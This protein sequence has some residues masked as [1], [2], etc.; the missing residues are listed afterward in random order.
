[1]GKIKGINTKNSG[2]RIRFS[3]NEGCTQSNEEGI[4]YLTPRSA[5]FG[6][7]NNSF[8]DDSWKDELKQS[9]KWIF[10]AKLIYDGSIQYLGDI[11]VFDISASNIS[12]NK[13]NAIGIG[14]ILPLA[15]SSRASFY[16]LIESGGPYDSLPFNYVSIGSVNYYR[17]IQKTGVRIKIL[18][19][20]NDIPYTYGKKKN[21]NIDKR[22]SQMSS[23]IDRLKRL[24]RGE[25]EL[26]S[27]IFKYEYPVGDSGE[28]SP[29]ICFNVNND[30]TW[31]STNMQAIIGSNG[32]GKT[33][34]LRNLAASLL[35]PDKQSYGKI[36]FAGEDNGQT[37]YSKEFKHIFYISFSIL[38]PIWEMKESGDLDGK[39]ITI[40]GDFSIFSSGKLSEISKSFVSTMKGIVE[41]EAKRTYW[42]EIMDSL[43]FIPQFQ[44]L[45]N[46]K[47]INKQLDE[48]KSYQKFLHSFEGLSAGHKS[49]IYTLAR[50]IDNDEENILVL[51]DEPEAHLHPPLLAGLVRSLSAVLTA[52][53]GVGIFA[54][55]SAVVLQEIPK[56][57]VW[58]IRRNEENMTIANPTI[59]TFGE[60][61]A[62]I[63]NT[64]FEYEI[65]NTGYHNVLK[66][67]ADQSGSYEEA[68]AKINNQLGE[69]GRAV[70]LNLIMLKGK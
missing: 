10:N 33:T 44:G 11:V 51:F 3:W 29:Y 46:C 14:Q 54:T 39:P 50:L 24:A 49:V 2:I 48:F 56:K 40:I 4:V 45:R 41:N 18:S 23:N 61:I 6:R 37:V 65:S 9:M 5:G 59:E 30:F 25:P 43:S 26:T 27:F 36:S 58:I 17:N 62:H 64:V 22:V 20:L 67:I 70:L 55:H 21:P 8:F 34:L 60:S 35:F 69:E 52:K 57:C 1:M 68:L 42:E 16:D 31:P 53:N 15:G 7:L 32:S 13:R 12:N 28:G 47:G 38:D 19:A 63:T 66:R